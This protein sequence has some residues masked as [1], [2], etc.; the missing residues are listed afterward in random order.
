MDEQI[1][2]GFGD[3]HGRLEN[4]ARIPEIRTAAGVIISGDLSNPG[5]KAEAEAII[6]AAR[7]LNGRVYAQIGNMDKKAAEAWL[8]EAGANIHR[9]AVELPDGA[10]MMGVGWSSPTPF[11]TPSEVPDEVL[12]GWL[13]ET[14]AKVGDP[15][16]LI[17]VCHTP[18]HGTKA[19]MTGRRAHVGSV[20]VREFLLRRR[21]PVCLTGH[22]HE[23]ACEDTLGDTR[24]VNPGMLGQGG[25]ALIR[26]RPQRIEIERKSV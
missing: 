5:G 15:S 16:R 14:W 2:V 4:M 20:A 1:Y 6:G 21:P 23:S 9:K 17:V 12:G 8:D 7:A 22:I 25:Y 19:D 10:W 24:I 26:V 11:G 13:E 18:P 3:V